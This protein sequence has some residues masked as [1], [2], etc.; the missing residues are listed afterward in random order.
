MANAELRAEVAFALT[1]QPGESGPAIDGDGHGIMS[2]EFLE[3]RVPVSWHE[4]I[5]NLKEDFADM[6]IELFGDETKGVSSLRFHQWIALRVGQAD[7]NFKSGAHYIGRGRNAQA[8]QSSLAKWV[9][10]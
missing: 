9:H 10:A 4:S 2:L 1:C 8:I 6:G 7:T 3:K 5:A